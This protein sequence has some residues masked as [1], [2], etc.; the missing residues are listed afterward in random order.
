[1]NIKWTKV[2]FAAGLA[3]AV[4]GGSAYAQ[5]GFTSSRS[6][7]AYNY[8]VQPGQDTAPSPSD[9]EIPDDP[10]PAVAPSYS[11]GCGCTDGCADA[12]C[13]DDGCCGTCDSCCGCGIDWFGCCDLG[14]PWT[15]FCND[16][17]RGITAGGWAQV[18]YHTQGVNGVGTGLFNNYPNRVQLHQL[19]FYVEKETDTGGCGW[20]FGFRADGVY[21]TDGPDTQAF[22]ARPNTWDNPWDYGSAYGAAIPQLYGTVAYND[23]TVKVGKFYTIIGYEGVMATS[24]FFYS[25]AYTQYLAE[26]FTHTGILADFAYND[27][28]T[29]FGGY[30][31]GWDTGYTRN[32]GDTFIGGISADLTCNLSATYAFTYGDFGAGNPVGA[33]DNNGYNHSFVVDW[34]INDRWEYVFQNDIV[35]NDA[36]LASTDMLW[37]VNQYLYYTLNDCW[38]F[39]VRAEVYDDPR[40]GDEFYEVTL[41]LNYKPHANVVIRPEVRF[42]EFAPNATTPVVANPRDEALFGVDIIM[43]F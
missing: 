19:Y 42:N 39:G 18:G 35:S 12:G 22:G 26:P 25:H 33:S 30:T 21:G 20:D 13:C 8:Y 5:Q 6:V 23:L 9:I 38:K 43:T 3:V 41:G 34:T 24:N 16:N 1:M 29:L 31:L 7:A 27:Y 17:C 14:D 40:L 2:A 4:L 11:V 37:S 10:A 15:L 36:F 32:S 28:V